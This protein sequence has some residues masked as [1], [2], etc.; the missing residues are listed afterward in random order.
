MT[1]DEPSDRLIHQRCRNRIMEALHTLA[2][3]DAGVREAGSNF[4]EDFYD[5]IPHRDHGEMAHNS[6][7]T[8]E[9]RAL[10]HRVSAILDDACDAKP[11]D[12]EPE[13]F[14]ATG[15]PKRIQAVATEALALMRARG[16]FSEDVEE[17][18]PSQR[19]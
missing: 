17:E 16:R 3:G 10:L 5:W 6:A 4:F 9:E 8:P 18:T 7:V 13:D 2:D 12:M 14:V 1:R 11:R 19:L 15:W